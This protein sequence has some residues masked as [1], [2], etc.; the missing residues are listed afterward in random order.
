MMN[1]AYLVH[2]KCFFQPTRMIIAVQLLI[3]SFLFFGMACRFFIAQFTL[4]VYDENQQHQS[5]LNTKRFILHQQV[6]P[7]NR[8]GISYGQPKTKIDIGNERY[9]ESKTTKNKIFRNNVLLHTIAR[10]NAIAD[11]K[12]ISFRRN[13]YVKLRS[14]AKEE[15]HEKE[16]S[17]ISPECPPYPYKLIQRNFHFP[18]QSSR[19]Q[20]QL[21]PGSKDLGAIIQLA[22]FPGSGNTWVR[23]L[24]ERG[25]GYL[26]GTIY[27]ADSALSKV[28]HGEK[29]HDG[30]KVDRDRER[31]R[32]K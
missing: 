21:V 32:V 16:I 18:H 1:S 3:W 31:E 4:Q 29:V 25:T 24:I 5:L 11:L 6:S 7:L 8:S 19:I 2:K 12:Y 30:R 20:R 13:S 9:I 26:T 23:H 14:E 28:F 22:S 10:Y 27:G 17:D 15:V